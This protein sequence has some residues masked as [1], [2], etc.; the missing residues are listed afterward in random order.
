MKGKK[1]A[2]DEKKEREK[3]LQQQPAFFLLHAAVT[4]GMKVHGVIADIRRTL[5]PQQHHAHGS[6]AFKSIAK[7]KGDDQT[8][9]Q[10]R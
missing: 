4:A 10:Q 1:S 7:G 2:H 8:A 9:K 5:A 6:S 3:Q